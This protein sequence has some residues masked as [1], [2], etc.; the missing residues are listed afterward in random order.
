MEKIEAGK[1]YSLGEAAEILRF[2]ER[3]LRRKISE[4]K[5]SYFF[6]GT[7]KFQGQHL[8][9]YF[10]RFSKKTLKNV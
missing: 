3:T 2:S 4:R 10:R 6:D 7:Y 9:D 8:L 1:L 5:I